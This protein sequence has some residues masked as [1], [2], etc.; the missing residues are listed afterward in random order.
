MARARAQAPNDPGVVLYEAWLLLGRGDSTRA[1]ALVQGIP[2]DGNEPAMMS[3]FSFDPGSSALLSIEQRQLVL[4]LK[5]SHFGDNR[6]GWGLALAFAAY[7]LGDS[8][9]VRAYADSALSS[10]EAAVREN[11]D[12]PNNHTSLGTAYALLGRK[13][14]AIREG[15]RA[16]AMRG[17]DGFQGPGLRYSLARIYQVVGEPVKAIEQ[18]DRLLRVP[19]LI[20]AGWLRAD[21]SL[22]EL[23]RHPRFQRLLALADSLAP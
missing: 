13:A 3:F 14:D 9:R 6:G 4:Q 21:P 2:K 16:V 18:F 11:P 17:D 8:A 12:E 10:L 20:S 7:T 15:E 1:R 5:P 19:S 23:R 22:A